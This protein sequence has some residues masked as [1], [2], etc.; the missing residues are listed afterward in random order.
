M[1]CLNCIAKFTSAFVTRREREIDGEGTQ[2]PYAVQFSSLESTSSFSPFS[3]ESLRNK[4]GWM[5]S[6]KRQ[7]RRKSLTS[8]SPTDCP[9]S[10]A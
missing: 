3:R 5:L 7:A 1:K 2:N 10:D 6:D 9:L 8:S 4:H